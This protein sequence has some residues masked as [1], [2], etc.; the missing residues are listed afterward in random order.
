MCRPNTYFARCHKLTIILLSI[1]LKRFSETRW[2]KLSNIVEFPTGENGLDMAPY[3][4]NS[5]SAKYTLYGISNHMGKTLMNAL[6]C[7]VAQF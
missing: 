2:S 4:A 3:A 7:V 5:S 1:D 6:M